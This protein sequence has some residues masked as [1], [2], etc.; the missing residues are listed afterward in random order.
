MSTN[1]P[2]NIHKFE[3]PADF[4]VTPNFGLT[5]INIIAKITIRKN[6]LS[7]KGKV[8]IN[9]VT[10]NKIKVS[11]VSLLKVLEKSLPYNAISRIRVKIL[12]F[13][14]WYHFRFTFNA[15]FINS[16]ANLV[17]VLF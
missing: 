9:I 12:L 17:A 11:F 15:K 13:L 4:Y 1:P 14:L 10:E 16:S 2:N 6:I 3:P 5:I 8:K 7:P